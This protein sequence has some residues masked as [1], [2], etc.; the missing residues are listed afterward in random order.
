MQTSLSQT[1]SILQTQ[2]RRSMWTALPGRVQSFDPSKQA[3]DI[4]P[5]IRDTWEGEDG[6]LQTG[7]LP[8]IP[9]VPGLCLRTPTFG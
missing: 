5:L 3:A 1:F 6:S 9:S 2:L 7:P 4:E 8:V